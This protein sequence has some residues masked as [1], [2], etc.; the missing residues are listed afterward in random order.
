MAPIRPQSAPAAYISLVA[1]SKYPV[2][3][4][5]AC[6]IPADPSPAANAEAVHVSSH[7]VRSA[8][9]T[10]MRPIRDI[11]MSVTL[12]MRE[13]RKNGWNLELFIDFKFIL[14]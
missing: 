13:N 14:Q 12:P 1:G 3:I 5:V 8:V 6:T 9:F 11:N 2:T 4:C 7:P 10:G